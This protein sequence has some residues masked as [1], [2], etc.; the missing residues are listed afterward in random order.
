MTTSH[1]K[2]TVVLVATRD[3][4]PYT[5]TSSIERS[6][7]VH[8]TTGYGVD[9]V[10]NAGGL[11]EGKFTMG[12][13]YDNTVLVGPSI[14]M[15]PLVGQAAPI[16]RRVEGT[17]SGKPQQTFT[18]I[19]EKFVESSPHDDMVTWSADWTISG[20]VTKTTQP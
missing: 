11:R 3:V 17:G 20:P 1:G 7:S 5:K 12:G 15:D 14:V 6:A 18:A 2:L 16:V 19:L 8:N 9:D 13:V 10:L 4:S